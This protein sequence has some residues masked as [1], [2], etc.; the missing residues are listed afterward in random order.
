MK[1]YKPSNKVSKKHWYWLVIVSCLGGAS[2][3]LVTSVIALFIYPVILFPML[4]GATGGFM[5][6]VGIKRAKVR[7][8]LIG[9]ISG[10]LMGVSIYG[11]M[12]F[13]DYLFFQQEVLT[14]VKKMNPALSSKEAKQ[15][16]N[17]W[18]LTK[19]GSSG[20]IGFIKASAEKG[21]DVVS[22]KLIGSTSV[23]MSQK[24]SYIYWL[25]EFLLIETFIIWVSFS[26]T[27]EA[28]CES[29][30]EWYPNGRYLGNVKDESAKKF[31]D[32]LKGGNYYQAGRL[33][34]P[35]SESNPPSLVVTHQYCPNCLQGD[36]ILKI[37]KITL[38]SKGKLEIN[39]YL[40]GVL[41]VAQISNVFRPLTDKY[42]ID[43]SYGITPDEEK[44][45]D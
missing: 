45:L 23:T 25:L 1:S 44:R 8:P 43:L 29:C 30:E 35:L 38:N 37:E 17:Q 26:A 13:G 33:I 15:R 14:E 2:L 5:N 12:T 4:L 40:T 39:P 31:A 11:S 28:F 3:G 36:Q 34:D 27:K 22:Y 9:G 10:L 19:T 41:S 6:R 16:L 20:F 24:G 42:K 7:N 18:L 21:V 32:F